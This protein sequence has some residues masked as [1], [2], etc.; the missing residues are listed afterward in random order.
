MA[1]IEFFSVE[2]QAALIVASKI[3]AFVSM[4]ASSCV[5]YKIL[6]N[7]SRR[8]VLKGR[9]ILSMSIFDIVYSLSF[10]IGTWAFPKDLDVWGASGSDLTCKIEGFTYHFGLAALLYNIALAVYFLLAV[11]HR[12]LPEK[13]IECCFH[14]TVLSISLLVASLSVALDTIRPKGIICMVQANEEDCDPEDEACLK[15]F[16]GITFLLGLVTGLIIIV[17]IVIGCATM[18]VLIRH[19][20]KT[21]QRMEQYASG[22]DGQMSKAVALQGAL[23]MA[24]LLISWVPAFVHNTIFWVTATP[25]Y[26]A[27]FLSSVTNPLQGMKKMTFFFGRHEFCILL[28]SRLLLFF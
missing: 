3:A 9:L 14:A 11:R 7:P 22:S 5:I 15:G 4:I 13:K 21:E 23:Y 18:C 6:T 20:R 16:T 28:F 12:R 19:V 10:F 25:S 17:A 8:R 27:W 26:A 1:I 2:Q 24:S